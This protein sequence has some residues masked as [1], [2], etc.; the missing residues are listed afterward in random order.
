MTDQRDDPTTDI[1]EADALEQ[2]R[3]AV[4]PPHD[5]EHTASEPVPD[6]VEADP[7]DV[8]EQSIDVPADDDDRDQTA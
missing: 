4:E 7:A 3:D 1:P 8:I 5:P 2:R 6:G